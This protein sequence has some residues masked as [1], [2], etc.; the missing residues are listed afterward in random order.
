MS[1]PARLLRWPGDRAERA[2]VLAQRQA[3]VWLVEPGIPPPDDWADWED[4]VRLPCREEDLAA[5]IVAVERRSDA[6]AMSAWIDDFDVL[7]QGEKWVPLSPLEGR[8]MKALLEHERAVVRRA[9]LIEIGWPSSAAKRP[10][11]L[12]APMKTLRRKAQRVGVQIH[13][14]AGRGYLAEVVRARSDSGVG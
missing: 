13:A 2:A 9:D 4:W 6:L 14:V 11:D 5:R 1:V 7:R 3:C 8:L 10:T 12:N